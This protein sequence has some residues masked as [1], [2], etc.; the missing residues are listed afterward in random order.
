MAARKAPRGNKGGQAKLTSQNKVVFTFAKK[1][2]RCVVE[3]LVFTGRELG[4]Y[5]KKLRI[6]VDK[7]GW[8]SYY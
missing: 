8:L 6:A 2:Y 4:V 1:D 7:W 3:G 5:G